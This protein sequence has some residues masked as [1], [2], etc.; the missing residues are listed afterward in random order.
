MAADLPRVRQ[1]SAE[2]GADGSKCRENPREDVGCLRT[3]KLERRVWGRPREVGASC[4]SLIPGSETHQ[5]H[6]EG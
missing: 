6:G 2:T 4:T 1:P 5:K 3:K